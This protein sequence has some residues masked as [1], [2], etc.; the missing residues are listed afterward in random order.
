MMKDDYNYEF[1]TQD[2]S[3]PRCCIGLTDE[4]YI[5]NL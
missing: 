4:Q 2:K 1:R 3:N 5:K